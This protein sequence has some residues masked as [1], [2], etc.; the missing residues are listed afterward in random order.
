[1]AGFPEASSATDGA[2]PTLLEVSTMLTEYWLFSW[3]ATCGGGLEGA[4]AESNVRATA[5]AA[6]LVRIP[7]VLPSKAAPFYTGFA[8]SRRDVSW[9]T[10]RTS[11]TSVPVFEP[12]CRRPCSGGPA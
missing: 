2:M 8:A 3:M 7:D 5:P 11:P 6:T 10:P 1:M 4:Q 12:G 9:R